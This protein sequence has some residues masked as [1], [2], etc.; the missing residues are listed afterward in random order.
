MDSA[1]DVTDLRP[2][3]EEEGERQQEQDDGAPEVGLLQ[4]EQ[5]EHAGHD[6]VR[7]EAHGE[8]LHLL[9]LLREGIGEPDHEGDLRHLG[10]LY[11][12]R[13]DR[14]P[15]GGAAAGVPK[16]MTHSKRRVPTSASTG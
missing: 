4:T 16:P 3:N 15:P 7:Q 5:H 6:E 1:E 14:Q 8:R 2:G 12:D 11:V 13:T 9:G 10:G